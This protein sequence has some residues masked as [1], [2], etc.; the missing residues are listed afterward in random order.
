MF[1]K[2]IPLATITAVSLT[3]QS[4]QA[5]MRGGVRGPS[6]VAPVQHEAALLK[7]FAPQPSPQVR[8]YGSYGSVSPASVYPSYP[9]N[10]PPDF[11][12][13]NYQHDYFGTFP[14]YDNYYYFYNV[15]ELS[16]HTIQDPAYP[17]LT[18]GSPPLGQAVSKPVTSSSSV[19]VASPEPAPASI[20]PTTRFSVA[21][22]AGAE[23]WF[24][25]TKVPGTGTTRAFQTPPLTPGQRYSYDVRARWPERGR[26]VEQTKRVTFFAGEKI[27]LEFEP[28]PAESQSR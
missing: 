12:T 16:P 20:S 9:G 28:S 26:D 4:G 25:G 13:P 3:V 23:V 19:S 1:K 22:P 10:R 17:E 2:W 24:D 8:Y 21:L 5:Q 6:P 14:Y 7:P 27:R 18:D 11:I 15:P